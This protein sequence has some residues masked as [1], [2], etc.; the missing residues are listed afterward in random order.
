MRRNEEE[1]G[2]Y[3]DGLGVFYRNA[4]AGKAGSEPSEGRE[5]LRWISDGIGSLCG[6]AYAGKGDCLSYQSWR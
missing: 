4:S 3:F 2:G 5:N 6:D 1:R